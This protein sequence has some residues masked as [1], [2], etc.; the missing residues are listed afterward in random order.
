[1][2]DR[3]RKKGNITV[4][5]GKGGVGKTTCAAAIA[6]HHAGRGESTLAISTDATPSLAHIFEVAD[7]EKPVEVKRAWGG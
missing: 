2:T 1:M 4:L 7:G 5:A 3:A 6:L